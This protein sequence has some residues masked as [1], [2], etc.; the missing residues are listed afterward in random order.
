MK[1]SITVKDAEAQLKNWIEQNSGNFDEYTENRLNR[2]II[3]LSH[4]VFLGNRWRGHKIRQN[5][6]KILVDY[7]TAELAGYGLE[8][9]HPIKT[10]WVPTSIRN[11]H[12]E[13][14]RNYGHRPAWQ[15][16]HT[17]RGRP[18]YQTHSRYPYH[19]RH[20]TSATLRT[21]L[22][23]ILKIIGFVVLVYIILYIVGLL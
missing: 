12:P 18:V 10:E 16:H 15:A 7:A 9:R 3:N 8:F 6:R 22:I 4:D 11:Y 5:I 2:E 23:F 13:Q 21:L 1:R 17:T 20:Q 19:Y 14:K